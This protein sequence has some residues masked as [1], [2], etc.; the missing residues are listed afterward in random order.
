[1]R[2]RIQRWIDQ[3]LAIPR[4][5]LG[6]MYAYILWLAV[7]A[8]FAGV[9]TLDLTTYSGYVT[10]WSAALALAAGVALVASTRKVWEKI[11]RWACL[12][13]IAD[14]AVYVFFGVALALQGGERGLARAAFAVVLLYLIT[15]PIVRQLDLIS[16]AGLAVKR[17]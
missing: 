14:L 8:A 10:P 7:T 15:G 3:R 16:R 12:V 1:M 9:P 17:S 5:L 13:I 11:E 2:K 6:V 4:W